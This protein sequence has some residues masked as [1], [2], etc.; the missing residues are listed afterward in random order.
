MQIE[1][2]KCH[3]WS[4]SD[5]SGYISFLYEGRRALKSMSKEYQEE[6][7]TIAKDIMRGYNEGIGTESEVEE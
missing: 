5:A 6:I 2:P 1:C 7:V 3:E 4:E